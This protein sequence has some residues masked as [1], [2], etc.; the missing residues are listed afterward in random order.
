MLTRV[1]ILSGTGAIL[2][3]RILTMLWG[4]VATLATTVEGW[5]DGLTGAG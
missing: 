3:R 4:W 1:G 5:L 2:L